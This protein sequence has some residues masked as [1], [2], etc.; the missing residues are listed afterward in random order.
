MQK[1]IGGATGEEE[2]TDDGSGAAARLPEEEG[3][4]P[5]GEGFAPRPMERDITGRRKMKKLKT[6]HAR[7]S[8]KMYVARTGYRNWR[9]IPTTRRPREAIIATFRTS[10]VLPPVATSSRGRGTELLRHF[11]PGV[12]PVRRRG[13]ASPLARRSRR[14]G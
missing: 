10:I 2:G 8:Q 13:R 7:N 12:R 3:A 6:I 9:V 4:G 5:G 11:P 1:P 14:I